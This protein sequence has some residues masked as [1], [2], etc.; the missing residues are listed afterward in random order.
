MK[1][2]FTS[3]GVL[4]LGFLSVAC[5]LASSTSALAGPSAAEG[6]G[7]F[8]VTG[9]GGAGGMFTPTVAP[10]DPKLMLLSCDMSGAYR[11][12]DGG[13]H[14][15]LIHY[16]Q[17]SGA[18]R[19][20][21]A[22][23]AKAI[24]WAGNSDGLRVSR[25]KGLTWQP[26]A[27]A[28]WPWQGEIRHIAAVDADPA[29]LAVG[30][31]KGLWISKDAGTTWVHPAAWAARCD[32]LLALGPAIYA[33]VGSAGGAGEGKGS[34]LL[35]V[36]FAKDGTWQV[37]DVPQ[38]KD[39]PITSLAGGSGLSASAQRERPPT[40]L[41][42]TIDAVGIV[43]SPDG[44]GRWDVVMPWQKQ[45]DILMPAGQTQVAYAAQ[46]NGREIFRTA[47]AGK[48]W[49][50][51]FHM[52]GPQKN[53]ELAW[54]QT[55]LHWDYSIM[56]LGLGID[57][58]N[59]EVVLVSTQGDF[60]RS[61]DGGK[62][63]QQMMNEPV[64]VQAGDPGFRYRSTGLEVTSVWN[65]VFDAWEANRR[66]LC[67]TDIGFA[68]SVDG[69]QTW[70]PATQGCPWGNTY[71]Q[72]AFDPWTKGRI[73][74]A[75]SNRHDIPHW[76]H[77]DSNKRGHVGGVCV[78]DNFGAS[79]RVLAPSLPK[80]PC[81]SIVI[82]PK[83]P[84]GKLTMYATFFED[85]VYKTTDGGQTW[86]KASQG[87]GNPGNLHVYRLR[88]HPATGDLYCLI[89]AFRD[90]SKFAVPGGVWRS[91]D[92]AATWKDLT[93]SAKLCWPNDFVVHPT[94]D[95]TIYIA[96]ATAPGK[97]EGGVWR[98]T[99]GGANWSHVLKD[100]DLAKWCPP[101]YTHGMMVRL[102]PDH[103]DWVYFGSSSH[104]QWLSRDGGTTWQVFKSFPFRAVQNITFDP[105]DS[106]I[107]H[108]STFGGGAW[109]GPAE[110]GK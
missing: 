84:Q 53:V 59:P 86:A 10:D 31:D 48:T 5:M 46:D 56:S 14:W 27:K 2:R 34:Q 40:T 25:D 98:T 69:G 105:K 79:W 44:G 106:S 49:T 16:K 68:R 58:A 62:S 87:L 88:I 101:T 39:H 100:A 8:T 75:C 7:G 91:T 32:A 61:A 96:A 83:S 73:Y 41:Y 71:F 55:V 89:T 23:A 92:G 81:T 103:P 76:T 30:T 29:R 78:S 109:Q 47:D 99:D 67:Y 70:I 95:K 77:V 21:P 33:A 4:M 20:R 9:M 11:S 24:Y 94:D 35:L 74:A 64:G 50:S 15:Q 97:A 12:T 93:A 13:A 37:I 22:F 26:V 107:I 51:I 3:P 63:W 85:G 6:G 90:G 18:L 65:Y 108:V 19:A 66:Y 43:Q 72:I 110:C 54:V 57:P 38:A 102:H 104:G 42:A 80:L 45:N 52:T 82:D 36:G 28:P 60:Y 17:L 1:C